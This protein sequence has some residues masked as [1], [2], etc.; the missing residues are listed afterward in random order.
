[1]K[2]STPWSRRIATIGSVLLGLFVAPTAFA[3]EA[4][5]LTPS[6]GPKM[7]SAEGLD[8]NKVKSLWLP[9]G[10]V[11]AIY[12]FAQDVGQSVVDVQS[13]ELRLPFDIVVS[14]SLDQG[15]TWSAPMNISNSAALSSSLGITEQTGAPVLDESGYPDLA[16]DPRAVAWPGDCDKP[17][18]FN[19]GNNVLVTWGSKYC[20]SGEQRFVVYPELNGV[21]V[22]YS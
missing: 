7:V 17:N 10:T 19:T 11:L 21:T 5:E 4:F 2:T 9:D 13:H 15:L 22:P 14:F 20:P 16:A 1:M 3:T 6:D 12:G 18:A 8:T